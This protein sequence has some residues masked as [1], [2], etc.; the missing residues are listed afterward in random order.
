MNYIMTSRPDP[1]PQL[2]GLRWQGRQYDFLIQH[3]SL[4]ERQFNRSGAA[5]RE[6]AH[7]VYHVVLYVDGR[8]RFTFRGERRAGARGTLALAS[9]GEP[10]DFGPC[11]RGSLAY[12]EL[13][14]SLESGDRAMR[15]PF[16]ELLALYSGIPLPALGGVFQLEEWQTR[17]LSGLLVD[18]LDLLTRRQ[19]GGGLGVPAAATQVLAVV[20]EVARG[21]PS[22]AGAEDDAGLFKAR[23]I[24]ESRFATPLT[25][26][27]LAGECKISPAYFCRRYKAAFG[28]S[29]VADIIR[30]RVE[31]AKV[32]LR[33]TSMTCQEVAGQTGFRD[34]VF[35]NKTFK[36]HA[37][38][39][40]DAFR[41]RRRG[42]RPRQPEPPAISRKS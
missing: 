10:H 8:N 5:P 3:L 16:N 37:G 40:P 13:T 6:H 34:S 12:H 41:R 2:L 33:T 31:A 38:E 39:T 23:R 18:L 15:L 4:E 29:P 36:R 1:A 19:A 28:I 22:S 32:L 26:R 9:P 35:F 20:L 42:E 30:V 21:G 11:D 7:A 17:Q 27:E 25:L 14:F 24:V